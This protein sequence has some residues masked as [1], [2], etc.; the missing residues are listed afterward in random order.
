MLI[1][2]APLRISIAGGGTDLPAYYKKY[3][4]E[5]ISA[6]IDKYVYITV[7][8][9]FDDIIR[10]CYSETEEV[11]KVNDIKHP[12][13]REALKLLDIDKGIE[14]FSAA[15]IPSGTGLGSS[16]SFTIALLTA[17]HAF[18]SEFPTRLQL[19]QEA[20]HIAIDILKEPSGLQDEYISAFGGLISF[21]ISEIAEEIRIE[22]L[23]IFPELEN[24][25]LMF[26]T[27]I[28]R[29]TS[30]V[31]KAQT[32]KIEDFHAIKE[33]GKEI[34]TALQIGN[35][36][37]FGKL[38]DEHWQEKIKRQGATTYEIQQW[39]NLAKKNGAIGGKI[40]G[41]GGGGFFLFYCEQ[42]DRLKKVMASAGLK[43]CPF[44]FEPEGAKI[45]YD[46]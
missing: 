13:F 30:P 19:A 14:I 42:Q 18:K 2:R 6:A 44:H 1:S 31:L 36:K 21:K 12:I 15:D 43:E 9:R 11:K 3:G 33:I 22:Q 10:V 45:I 7:H 35:F 26:Y 5:W 16:G 27:G 20:C 8:K 29:K 25:L 32:K 40:M 23:P 4:G 28:K 37:K 46:N 39:Y 41:A 24:N 17:L 34:K 38:L